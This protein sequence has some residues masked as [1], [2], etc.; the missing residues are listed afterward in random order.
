[1]RPAQ[2]ALD[3]DVR[4]VNYFEDLVLDF[5]ARYSPLLAPL[6]K[7]RDMSVGELGIC[8][9]DTLAACLSS[10][11]ICGDLSSPRGAGTHRHFV[12]DYVKFWNV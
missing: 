11:A 8:C 9:N 1:M 12:Y 6:L 2:L 5:G 10:C 4:V 7:S 3:Q